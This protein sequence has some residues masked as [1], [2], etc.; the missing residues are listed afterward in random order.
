ME[1]YALEQNEIA[2]AIA[3][4]T[5]I[6]LFHEIAT[7][8][9]GPVESRRFTDEAPPPLIDRSGCVLCRPR[10]RGFSW[11]D[12]P[13]AS[14]VSRKIE[15]RRFRASTNSPFIYYSHFYFI[16]EEFCPRWITLLHDPNNFIILNIIKL[17]YII[18]N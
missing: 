10:Y 18:L 4:P 7:P 15:I 12:G 8:L 17:Y 1:S 2:N 11:K 9:I 14:M 6:P 5:A 13:V 3:W 16:E